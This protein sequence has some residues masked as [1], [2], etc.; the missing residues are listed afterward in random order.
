[1]ELLEQVVEGMREQ[2]EP[3]DAARVERALSIARTMVQP[4]EEQLATP[5]SGDSGLVTPSS[6]KSGPPSSEEGG[7]VTP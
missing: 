2:G 5:S 4:E 6:E 7:L 3:E 1:L